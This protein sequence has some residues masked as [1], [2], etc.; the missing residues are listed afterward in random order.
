MEL[1]V[2]VVVETVVD[3]GGGVVAAAAAVA[4]SSC[5]VDV[6][7]DAVAEDN[8]EHYSMVLSQIERQQ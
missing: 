5:A 4:S 1:V 3:I 2:L 7:F 8:R 6:P